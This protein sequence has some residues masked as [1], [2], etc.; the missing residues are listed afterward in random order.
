MREISTVGVIGLGTM[1]AGIVEV[2]AR[3]G[4]RVVGV[5]TTQEYAD[6]GRA[7]LQGSTDRA[8][9][10]GRLD[11]N[12]KLVVRGHAKVYVYDHTPFQRTA[13]YRRAQKVAKKLDRGLWGEC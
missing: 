8:V 4:L 10:K 11:V 9:A 6:R 13:S 3:G 1:G 2:F 5:E 12:R 7:I